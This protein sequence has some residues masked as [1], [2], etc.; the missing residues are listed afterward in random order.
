VPAHP[1]ARALLAAAQIPIAAPSA[2]L[3]SRP[4]PTTAAHV[5]TD[6]RDRI[7]V[8]IDGGATHVGVESTVLAL[9][10]E[11]PAILRPG[12][13]TE[14]MLRRVIPDVETR[15]VTT[16]ESNAAASPGTLAKHYSPR[17]PLTLYDGPAALVRTRM[18]ADAAAATAAGRRPGPAAEVQQ[19]KGRWPVHVLQQRRDVLADV[20]VARAFPV[21]LGVLLVV[22]QGA[23]D[24][25]PQF[26]GTQWHAASFHAATS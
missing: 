5:L 17:A 18:A 15:R 10:G 19:V 9:T 4:S 11:R 8:V 21:V 1:I 26:F 3:F 25:V 23:R 13:I 16:G 6:L 14:E 2:N 7:D 12:A 24:D 20:V 22:R